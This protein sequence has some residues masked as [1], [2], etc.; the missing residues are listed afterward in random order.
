MDE[1]DKGQLEQPYKLKRV[2]Y[3]V[4]DLIFELV[5]FQ[6]T[7]GI[8]IV[9]NQVYL[10]SVRKPDLNQQKISQAVFHTLKIAGAKHSHGARQEDNAGGT[11]SLESPDQINEQ[12]NANLFSC[13]QCGKAFDK[14]L[15]FVEHWL[16]HVQSKYIR[17]NLQRKKIAPLFECKI[18]KNKFSSKSSLRRH[19]QL[20]CAPPVGV[21]SQPKSDVKSRKLYRCTM[22]SY[23]TFHPGNFAEHKV[24]HSD[25]TPFKCELCGGSFKSKKRLSFHKRMTHSNERPFKCPYCD[26]FFKTRALVKSH[27]KYSHSNRKPFKCLR[28]PAAF[29]Q[30]S[31]LTVHHRT[32]SGT[33]PFKCKHCDYAA[34]QSGNLTKHIMRNHSDLEVFKG[35]FRDSYFKSTKALR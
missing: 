35:S 2:T 22:C 23:S 6:N 27:L 34:C 8:F 29:K 19:L 13:Y 24:S 25:V 31:D 18:C 26:Q 1:K 7:L 11:D 10:K 21:L 12:M 4:P 3:E 16:K 15:D 9:G 17:H 14:K 20:V 5:T 30:R 32:H 28:C 33:K